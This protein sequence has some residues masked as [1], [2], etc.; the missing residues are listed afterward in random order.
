MSKAMQEAQR[1]VEIAPKEVMTRMNY[2][3][4]A[5]YASEFESCERGA[6]ESLQLNQSM[7]RPCLPSVCATRAES[8]GAS[9]G[10]LSKTRK[11]EF[12]GH[13]SGLGWTRDLAM[14][15][16]RFRDAIQILNKGIAVDLA[17]K[18]PDAASD[19]LWM[20]AEANLLRGDKPAA[21]AAADRALANNQSTKIR[22]LTARVFVEA[23]EIAKAKKM[24]EVLGSELQASPQ[25]YAKVILGEIAL[26]TRDP[27]VAIQLFNDAK[28]LLDTWIGRY[29]LGRAYLAAEAFAEADSEFDR[30][31]K[32]RGEALE[33]F[34]DD[35]PTYSLLPA[36][37][38][39]QGL[40][41]AGLNSPGAADS[42]RKYLDL[43]GKNTEDPLVA[44]IRRRVA[45]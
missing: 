27:K 40:A 2:S 11:D 20:L 7:K 37:Y 45:K 1:A 15:E 14:Y 36:V 18:N 30:C 38:Y 4:Y 32:R 6:H 39:Y 25:A 26:S 8:T 29:D 13:V 35:M 9:D 41:R 24:A 34:M 3:L 33:L 22:F 23:G 10:K 16:G 21:V 42:Y 5:C 43:R 17:A 31:I 44:D 12:M 19:K 28:N